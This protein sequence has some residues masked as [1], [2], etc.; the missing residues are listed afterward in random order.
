M[1]AS[2]ALYTVLRF[3]F[4]NMIVRFESRHVIDDTLE[5]VKQKRK[6]TLQAKHFH[7]PRKLPTTHILN[8]VTNL[9]QN[10]Q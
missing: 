8:Q 4:C 10:P 9:R 5:R 3:T 6:C 2:L 7:Y 1:E